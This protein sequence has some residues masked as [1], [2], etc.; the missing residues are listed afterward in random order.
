MFNGMT[1]AM[2]GEKMNDVIEDG[3]D[4]ARRVVRRSRHAAEDIVDEASRRVKRDPLLSVAITFGV[5]LGL[6]SAI[7]WLLARRGR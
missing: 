5:G 3:Y 1:G 7:G 4:A 6:G 2:V